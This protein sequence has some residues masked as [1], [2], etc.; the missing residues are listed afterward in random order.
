MMFKPFLDVIEL[1]IH[2]WHF[3]VQCFDG[4]G[5]PD[6]CHYV[7]A[8]GVHQVFAIEFPLTC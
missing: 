4:V 1:G 7:L 3:L 6:T 2:L 8:L 5:R